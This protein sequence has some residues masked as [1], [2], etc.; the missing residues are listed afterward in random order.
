MKM[1]NIDQINYK[2]SIIHTFPNTSLVII[3]LKQRP[4]GDRGVAMENA[5]K[6]VEVDL[7]TGSALA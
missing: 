2:N 7:N 4:N 3:Y 5:L 1:L 6:L